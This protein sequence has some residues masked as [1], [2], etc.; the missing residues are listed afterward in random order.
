LFALAGLPF[1]VARNPY[2]EI[3]FSLATRKKDIPGCTDVE[4]AFME[5]QDHWASQ[6]AMIVYVSGPHLKLG[7]YPFILHGL[8]FSV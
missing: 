5:S 7:N 3:T 1:D 8:P 4:N 6:V 2:Y